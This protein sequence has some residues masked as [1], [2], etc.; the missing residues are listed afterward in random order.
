MTGVRMRFDEP[1]QPGEA[2]EVAPGIYWI[3]LPLP[4]ALDHANIYALEEADGW[5]MVDTGCSTDRSRRVW[6]HL[7]RHLLSRGPVRRVVLT[8]FHPDHVGLAGW[9][10]STHGAEV[11]STRTTWLLARMLCL[12]EQERPLPES[13][14][15]LRAAGTSRR[16]LEQRKASRPFNFAD[17][18]APIP[19]GYR[20]LVEGQ[21]VTMGGR[22]WVVRCGDGHAPEHATFWCTG[23]SIVIGGDQFLADISPNIGVHATEPEANPVK[24]WLRSCRRFRKISNDDLLV[25][26]GHKIPFSGLSTRLDELITEQENALDRLRAALCRPSTAVECFVA[27]YRRRITEGEFGLAL[28]E[29]VAN[30]NY[31]H[32]RGEVTR[33]LQPEGKWQWSRNV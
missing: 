20:R 1:P 18:V 6:D 29:A 19:L 22:E 25:L 17:V 9:L 8:H 2:Q 14:R 30:L 32:D 13:I 24:E 11:W 21:S 3:R 5:T 4:F 15:F 33:T 23:E 26:P 12:D 28:S 7:F 16:I 27:L 10:V 31:L